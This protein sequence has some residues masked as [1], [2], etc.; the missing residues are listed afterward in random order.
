MEPFLLKRTIYWRPDNSH[1]TNKNPHEYLGKINKNL[2]EYFEERDIN[3]HESE[4]RVRRERGKVLRVDVSGHV[5]SGRRG[6]PMVEQMKA[7][8]V[9]LWP[10][11]QAH[12]S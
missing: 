7:E 10:G 2:H 11:G 1:Q 4:V 12:G 5:T 9:R 3:L 8:A 6:R